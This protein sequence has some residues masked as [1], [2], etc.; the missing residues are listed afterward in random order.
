[1]SDKYKFIR[2][3]HVFIC[4]LQTSIC[5]IFLYIF[6]YPFLHFRVIA[7]SNDQ[8]FSNVRSIQVLLEATRCLYSQV[9]NHKFC[10]KFIVL[11]LLYLQLQIVDTLQSQLF[12]V[13]FSNL[14]RCGGEVP[15]LKVIFS[16]LYYA[17]WLDFLYMHD[18]G[19]Y[20]SWESFFLCMSITL[21]KTIV[22]INIFLI[23]MFD[24]KWFNCYTDVL[25]RVIFFKLGPSFYEPRTCVG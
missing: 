14:H 23:S 5:F 21:V 10:S 16:S 7:F 18:Y 12:S 2:K 15:V 20:F 11:I 1:M 9:F 8:S 17:S 4:N 6:Y 25:D 13:N 19:D 22:V 24:R 3:P